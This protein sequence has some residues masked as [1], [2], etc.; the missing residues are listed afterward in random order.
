LKVKVKAA[1]APE[2]VVKRIN[3]KLAEDGLAL[4]KARGCV[5]EQLGDYFLVADDSVI[6]CNLSLEK[7][8][9]E[10]GALEAWETVLC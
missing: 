9:K 7:V 5:A 1:I 6:K 10:K 2:V 8:A 3:R 4:R